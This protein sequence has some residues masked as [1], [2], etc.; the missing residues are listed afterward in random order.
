MSSL[1]INIINYLQKIREDK[2]TTKI[3]MSS[4]IILSL[5]IVKKLETVGLL[6]NI[7]NF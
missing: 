6:I 3:I 5:I 1:I 4:L 7:I 2:E